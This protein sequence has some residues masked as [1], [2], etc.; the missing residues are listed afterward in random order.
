ML[1]CH[2]APPP[3]P[4]YHYVLIV[5]RGRHDTFIYCK[6]VFP[7]RFHNGSPDFILQVCFLMALSLTPH[8]F[9]LS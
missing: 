9:L 4:A 1:C 5:C 8:L 2:E 7:L 6:P 3:P